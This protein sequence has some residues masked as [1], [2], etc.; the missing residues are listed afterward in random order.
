MPGGVTV[1]DAELRVWHEETPDNDEPDAVVDGPQLDQVSIAERADDVRDEV[2]IAAD[3]PPL[4]VVGGY[5]DS[6]GNSYGGTL[7]E[8][9]DLRVG[10]RVEFVAG[11]RDG[12]GYGEGYGVSYGTGLRE[13][14]WTGRIQPTDRSRDG[15]QRPSGSVSASATDYVG[16][17]LSNRR[18]TGSWVGEDVGAVIR[19][20]VDRA[21]TE[22]D[23]SNVPDVGVT[24]DEFFQA[25]DCWDAVVT[26][27]AKGDVLLTQQGRALH[28]EPVGGL[29]FAFDVTDDDHTLPWTTNTDDD[30][31]NVVRVDSGVSRRQ[32]QAQEI[33]DSWD[34]VTETNRL[35]HRLRA[36]KSDIHSV[37]LYVSAVSDEGLRLRLQADE[38][39]APVA[40]GD[41]DSDI[42]SHQWGG[43]NIPA[44]GWQTWFFADHVLPDRDPWLIVET[45]GS[46]G[47]DIGVNV[48]GVPTFRSYYSHPLTYEVA[49]AD[50][51]ET[52]G[53]REISIERDNLET[54]TAVRD[55]AR[56]ELARRA[57]PT[58]TIEF[59]ADSPRAHL[60]EP[61]D[62]IGVD[63]PDENAV[64]DF[65]VTEVSRDFDASRIKIH[66]DVTATWRKGVL[67]PLN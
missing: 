12:P 5:G 14:A 21:T 38:G 61:G 52:F 7:E 63:K 53:S 28:V 41:E 50:S 13:I 42:I 18:I 4:D 26:L 25:R 64:G 20:I 59:A 16:A 39:G 19:D 11:V 15:P 29:P 62:V 22:I 6:Y 58:K 30:I 57:W 23:A 36:R 2:E 17:I 8:S 27:A 49:A 55:A 31:H 45:D 32:E 1:A 24:T 65:I 51:V 35:T 34:R 56:A 33:Q 37:D 44:E 9:Y 67:A 46:E 60:L 43:D 3:Y 54:V 40:I 48:D 10:D 47:H 66:T